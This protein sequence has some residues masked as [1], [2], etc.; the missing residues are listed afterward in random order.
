MDIQQNA[1]PSIISSHKWYQNSYVK[2]LLP[3]ILVF[4]LIGGY[5]VYRTLNNPLNKVIAIVGSE[6]IYQ[7]DYNNEQQYI[8]PGTPYADQIIRERLINDSLALQA[9]QDEK[10]VTLDKSYFNSEVKDYKKRLQAVEGIKKLIDQ[11]VDTL[12]GTIIAVWFL[13][14][15]VGPLGYSQAK[16]VALN[17]ITPIYN[18]VKSGKLTVQQAGLQL[19]NDTSL[20]Q[21]DPAYKVNALTTFKI[22]KGEKLTLDEKFDNSLWELPA[23]G[24]TPITTLKSQDYG[25]NGAIVDAYFVF[26]L[27]SNKQVNGQTAGFE[28]WLKQ[29]QKKYEVKYY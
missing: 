29:Q 13:N 21:L 28:D 16:Q 25:N 11:K 19:Q 23:G 18:Q 5:L 27:V 24:L 7:R 3:T 10:F 22:K 26:A 14:N 4:L 15:K 17:K 8:T 1:T 12:E 2:F 20:A 9:A 6:K